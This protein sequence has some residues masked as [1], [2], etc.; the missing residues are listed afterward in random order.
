MTAELLRFSR[1]TMI[2][3]GFVRGDPAKGEDIGRLA[4]DRV[5]EEIDTLLN[6]NILESPMAVESVVTTEFLPRTKP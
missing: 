3:E 6:L 2:R 5:K 4:L 1:D